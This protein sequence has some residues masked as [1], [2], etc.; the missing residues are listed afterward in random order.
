M[1]WTSTS[2]LEQLRARVLPFGVEWQ[3]E[4]GRSLTTARDGIDFLTAMKGRDDF[5]DALGSSDSTTTLRGALPARELPPDLEAADYLR[6]LGLSDLEITALLT[7]LDGSVLLD[8]A[9]RSAFDEPTPQK[10][11]RALERVLD[12]DKDVLATERYVE[13]LAGSSGIGRSVGLLMGT[14]VLLIGTMLSACAAQCGQP[15]TQ[16][17]PP[18]PQQNETTPVPPPEPPP[19]PPP[20]PPEPPRNLPPNAVPAYKGVS[21]RRRGAPLP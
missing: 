6:S 16:P 21:P 4:T 2:A 18:Q 11:A 8:A 5:W 9:I 1:S 13:R 17:R 15:T 10:V 19:P 7:G 14:A 20:P 3:R 12:A